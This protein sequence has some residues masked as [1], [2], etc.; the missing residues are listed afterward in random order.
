[1]LLVR[2]P[3]YKRFGEMVFKRTITTSS[4]RLLSFQIVVY[5]DEI[6]YLASEWSIIRKYF[7]FVRASLIDFFYFLHAPNTGV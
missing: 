7:L 3:C 4:Y 1:M 6:G 5:K 2:D